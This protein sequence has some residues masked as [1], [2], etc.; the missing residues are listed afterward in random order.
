MEEKPN[1]KMTVCKSCQ[2]E[3]AKSAKKCPHCGE[4]LKTGLFV[5]I[6][7]VL[8]VLGVISAI[9]SPSTEDRLATLAQA[10]VSDLSPGG[11]LNAAFSILSEHTDIQRENLERDITGTTVI[12][13]LP[14]YEVSK[15][16]DGHYRV[17]TAGS[18]V[19]G[20]FAEIYTQSADEANFIE[21]LIEDDLIKFKGTITGTFLRN[22][23]FDPA[24]LVN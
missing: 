8:I 12:W 9:F 7:T 6:L 20:T 24:I 18:G 10:T 14:I 5:K 21:G 16:T 17:Q 2:K 4:T 3:V 1:K 13:Q 15:I 22:I 19:V 11:E 23:E